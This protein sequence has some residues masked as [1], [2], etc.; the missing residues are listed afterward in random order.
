MIGNDGS[1]I[2]GESMKNK[3]LIVAVF[4]LLIGIA[5][6]FFGGMKYQ[7]SKVPA[8]RGQFGNMPN[9]GVNSQAR[10]GAGFRPVNGEVVSAD[11][12]TMTV[13]LTDG[14]SKIVILSDKTMVNKASDATKSDIAVGN[15]VAVFG[16]DNS[17]GSV[18]AQSVQINPVMRV[19]QPTL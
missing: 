12:K 18:T 17:D 13:K 10:N 11:E 15:K 14:S 1:K 6:G 16:T 4:T 3:S 5:V 2:G 19:V 8:F 9:L 7:E